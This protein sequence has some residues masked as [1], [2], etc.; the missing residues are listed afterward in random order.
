MVNPNAVRPVARITLEDSTVLAGQPVF[1]H[2]M[3]SSLNVGNEIS[4]R[5][6]WNFGDASGKYNQLVGFN[7]SHVYERPGTYTLTLRVWN[8]DRGMHAAT[9]TITVLPD[10]RPA[11]YVAANGNDGN[12]GTSANNPVRSVARAAQLLAGRSDVRVLFRSGDTFNTST[13]LKIDGSDVTIGAYGNGAR[14]KLNWVGGRAFT[15]MVDMGFG[16]RDVVVQGLHFDSIY[17]S[18]NDAHNMPYP[19][20]PQNRNAAFLD[21]V[22]E[23]MG[24][25]VNANGSPTNVLIQGNV[26]PGD[27]DLR[28]YF[29]WI[30]GTDFTLMGN[31]VPNSTREHIVRINGMQRLLVHGNEFTEKDR[32]GAGDQHDFQK[33]AIAVQSGQYAYLSQNTFAGPVALGPLGGGDGLASR[34]SRFRDV[35]LESNLVLDAPIIAAHGLEDAMLRGNVIRANGS[36]AIEVQGYSSSFGRGVKDLWVVNNTVVNS[37]TTGNFMHVGGRVDGINVINNLYSAPNLIIGPYGAAGI[38]S[39]TGIGDFDQIRNNVW[40]NGTSPNW[41]PGAQQFVGGG[42]VNVGTWN[43]YS[44][45]SGDVFSDVPVDNA[46][47]PANGSAA[48]GHGRLVDGLF[49]DFYNTWFADTRIT[50][51]AVQI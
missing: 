3:T 46:F 14:P 9:R 23:D 20:S 22:I 42:F 21:N 26:V 49:V 5:Y 27:T 38:A 29:A 4:A 24:F 6:E 17:D 39:N 33:S 43:G 28:N 48:D 19:F 35:V 15:P 34:H 18:P 2:G 37:R 10:N 32:R 31:K 40:Q 8:E 11:I 25:G 36:R 51:G 12:S 44:Q 16:A 13:G 1:V 45:T 50:A 7:A 47:R 41:S 30:Q